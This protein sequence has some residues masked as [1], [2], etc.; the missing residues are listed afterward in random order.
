MHSF[1]SGYGILEL[2]IKQAKDL[3]PMDSNGREQKSPLK[4]DVLEMIV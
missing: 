3:V 1:V 2:N 4:I